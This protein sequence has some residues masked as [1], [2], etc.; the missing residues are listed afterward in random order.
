[1][2]SAKDETPAPL[3]DLDYLMQFPD[4]TR[5]VLLTSFKA[6]IRFI[7]FAMRGEEFKFQ[8]FHDEIINAYEDIVFGRN[9]KPNLAI[10]ISPRSGKSTI[11]KYSVAWGY[12]LNRRS[13]FLVTSYAERLT[14]IFSGEIMD[15]IKNKY[16]QKLFNISISRDTASKDLWR[17]KDGG[18]FRAPPA[19]GTIIGFGAGIKGDGFAGFILM[20]DFINPIFQNSDIEKKNSIELYR[21]AVKTRRNNLKKTPM[22]AIMQRV[23]QDDLI[24]YIKDNEAE[25]WHFIEV[26]AI[27]VNPE[28]GEEY[29]F[30][31]EEYPIEILRRM[32]SQDAFGFAANY[33][34]KPIPFGGAMI[35][36]EWFKYYDVEN[37]PNF[38]EIF[39]TADTAFKAKESSDYTAIGVWG[40]TPNGKLC[41]LD[42]YHRRVDA[43][44]LNGVIMDLWDKWSHDV[45]YSAKISAI[46]IEDAASGMQLIQMLHQQTGLPVIAFKPKNVDKMMRINDATY[47]IEAGN[48][49]LPQNNYH[50]ISRE[51]L[52][53]AVQIARDGS[54][55]HDDIMDMMSIAIEKKLGSRRGFF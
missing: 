29:S 11:A 55:K 2:S 20:D 45:R 16:Y 15:I 36:D 33:M 12:A 21:T 32:R 8:P 6:F 40:H 27:Q 41:L 19:Q 54:H 9:D 24:G 51:V 14:N 10:C 34:Q 22:I 17:I 50:P 39:M 3:I 49:L 42:L 30:W 38:Y 43:V 48:V 44:N 23:A 35:K 4:E 7:H 31:P 13:N 1:M 5:M 37:P 28:T 52:A 47:S 46:Y 18:I 26:P 25:D 53:E